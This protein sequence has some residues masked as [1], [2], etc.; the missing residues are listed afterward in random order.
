MFRTIWPN[1]V[2]EQK[3]L[4]FSSTIP[5]V[6]QTVNL[7]I[8]YCFVPNTY[9]VVNDH[10]FILIVISKWHSSKYFLKI[11]ADPTFW[12]HTEISVFLIPHG[13]YCDPVFQFLP[14]C[15]QKT[16]LRLRQWS[17]LFRFP[18]GVLR[19]DWQ[20][21]NQSFW[22]FIAHDKNGFVESTSQFPNKLIWETQNCLFFG[23]KAFWKK[24][25][26]FYFYGFFF[27]FTDIFII[28]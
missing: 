24:A 28:I 3:F 7:V 17:L 18:R 22:S 12:V 2:C 15:W 4:L 16:D 9:S 11:K 21:A 26:Q 5:L 6:L 1:L 10:G 25:V 27:T 23:M 8:F 20:L 14:F 19:P 13:M